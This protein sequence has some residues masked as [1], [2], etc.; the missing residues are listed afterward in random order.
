M[1]AATAQPSSW[2][3]TAR[4]PSSRAARCAASR[5]AAPRPVAGVTG[6]TGVTGVTGV[7]VIPAGEHGRTRGA[8]GAGRACA[9]STHHPPRPRPAFALSCLVL[10]R[11]CI[12]FAS[13]TT[14]Y[15][16]TCGTPAPTRLAL[17]LL[18]AA[19]Q[20]SH[21]AQPVL[22]VAHVL[23]GHTDQG[24]CCCVRVAVCCVR[25]MQAPAR[26][27]N[28]TQHSSARLTNTSRTN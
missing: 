9:A 10:Y 4:P 8:R 23:A 15:L 18:D 22:L 2:G 24:G 3:L 19:Q 25:R 1:T 28:R 17:A 21:V 14:S 20:P 26:R 13:F 6:L 16:C 5:P 27:M 12:V 7:S 11:L